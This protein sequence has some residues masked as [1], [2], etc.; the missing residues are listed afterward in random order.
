[1]NALRMPTP[2][3]MRQSGATLMLFVLIMP[4]LLGFSA[5]SVDI[6]RV[7]LA[8]QELQNAAD[9]AALAGGAG[10]DD[11]GGETPYN[12]TAAQQAAASMIGKNPVSGRQL[13]DADIITG[14]VQP[15]DAQQN[16]HSPY[17]SGA[18]DPFSIP[19]VR[20]KLSLS[21]GHNG[22]PLDLVFGNILGSPTKD[23]YAEATAA[24]YPPGYAA[25]G[26]L[27]PI[28]LGN[29]MYDLYWDSV[30]RAPKIDPATSKPYQVMIGSTYGGGTCYSG[31]WSTFSGLLNDVPAVQA[32]I[33]GGNPVPIRVGDTTY[34]QSGVKD[35][36]YNYV[37]VNKV[38]AVPVVKKVV[39]GSFQTVTAIAAFQIE[40]VKRIDG[41]SYI[42]GYFT[43]GLKSTGLSSGSGGGQY[44]GAQ[45]GIPSILIR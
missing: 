27:F 11:L 37:P 5:L 41:K 33:T 21:V 45:T 44:L 34:I 24:A 39:T 19:V 3:E 13:M 15:S 38:V 32:L 9:A 35:A 6:S 7:L 43:T 4:L 18:I 1:M 23:I 22:G 31:E 40:G 14:Y 20:V 42:S 10:L 8:K 2:D 26:S 30:K 16:I 36:V 12:W 25:K 29:C 28:V 17:E